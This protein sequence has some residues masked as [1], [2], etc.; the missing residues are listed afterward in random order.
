MSGEPFVGS[1][2]DY[3]MGAPEK[4]YQMGVKVPQAGD[5]YRAEIIPNVMVPGS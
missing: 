4:N 3:A 2:Y 5:Y 1:R